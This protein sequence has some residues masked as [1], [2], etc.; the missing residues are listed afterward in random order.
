MSFIS[1]I[2]Q[3]RIRPDNGVSFSL[4]TWL[5]PCQSSSQS[6]LTYRCP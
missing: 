5:L 4:N 6:I 3:D 1:V 2:P